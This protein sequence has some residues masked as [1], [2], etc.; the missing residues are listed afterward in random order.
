MSF[1]DVF[2][3]SVLFNVMTVVF[4]S[5]LDLSHIFLYIS[6]MRHHQPI[7]VEAFLVDYK[8]ERNVFIQ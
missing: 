5:P 3:S 1:E 4:V 2:G 8:E 6:F 7:T